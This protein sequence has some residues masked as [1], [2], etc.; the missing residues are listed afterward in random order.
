MRSRSRLRLCLFALFLLA[1][2]YGI[3]SY[4]VNNGFNPDWSIAKAKKWCKYK[5]W[6]KVS[7]RPLL[8]Y[9]FE[10]SYQRGEGYSGSLH[11]DS[12]M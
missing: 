2:G 7:T 6:V 12:N 3:Y 11:N 1:G 4:L 9:N 10:T 8:T 5:K